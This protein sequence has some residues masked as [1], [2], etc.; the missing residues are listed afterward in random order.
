MSNM[1]SV[2][3]LS[4]QDIESRVIKTIHSVFK[5]TI[6]KS[7]T[8][9]TDISEFGVDSLDMVEFVLALETEFGIEIPDEATGKITNVRDM[10]AYISQSISAKKAGK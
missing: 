10:V 1:E 5:N 8:N 2:E 7:I 9:D 6:G 4:D 3:S